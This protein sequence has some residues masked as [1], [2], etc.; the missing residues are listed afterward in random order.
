MFKGLILVIY[1]FYSERLAWFLSDVHKYKI[2]VITLTQLI[3][4]LIV[5]E[6]NEY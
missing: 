5:K 1:I 6:C 3:W 4:I 2:F